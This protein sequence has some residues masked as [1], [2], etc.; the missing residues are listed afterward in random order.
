M[1]IDNTNTYVTVYFF[2]EFLDDRGLSITSDPSA[3]L[4]QAMDILNQQTFVGSKTDD[5]QPLAWPRSNV[6][7]RDRSALYD[8]SETPT[9]IKNALCYLAYYLDQNPDFSDISGFAIKK[10]MVDVLQTEFATGELGASSKK[11]I[12]DLPLFYNEIKHT[13]KNSGSRTCVIHG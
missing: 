7:N 11:T 3:L 12:R 6:Y 2:T 8:S 1:A 13:L 5:A 9:T 4:F 10:T